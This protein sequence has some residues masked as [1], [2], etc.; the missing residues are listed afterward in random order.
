M[1]KI[2]HTAD[3]HLD[4]PLKSLVLKDADLQ[5]TVKTATRSAFIKIVDTAL[6]EE[7]SALLI[8]GDLFDGAERSA[9]TAAFLTTQLDRLKAAEI[10]AFYIK[11]NH[12]GVVRQT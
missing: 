2:L 9:K 10:P 4:S 6:V 11:G 12:D 1:I 8:S 5:S 7:V 3:V